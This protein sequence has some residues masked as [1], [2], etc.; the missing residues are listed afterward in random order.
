MVGG[1]RPE[2]DVL[3]HSKGRLTDGGIADSRRRKTPLVLPRKLSGERRRGPSFANLREKVLSLAGRDREGLVCRGP[4]VILWRETERVFR[5]GE[6]VCARREG[7]V[8]GSWPA[9]GLSTQGD[10]GLV[11]SLS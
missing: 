3:P 10:S 2:N 8:Q 11:R 9:M 7:S 4:E 6:C 1:D 5:R